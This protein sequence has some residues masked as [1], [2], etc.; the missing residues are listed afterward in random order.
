MKHLVISDIHCRPIGLSIANEEIGNVDMV[1]FL[2]DYLDS[3]DESDVQMLDNFKKIIEFK[4]TYDDKVI[5]LLGN[6]CLSY[7]DVKYKCSGFRPQL[8]PQIYQLFTENRDIFQIAYQYKNYLFTHAGVS[9]EWLNRYVLDDK[10]LM[11]LIEPD[12]NNM[13]QFLNDMGQTRFRAELFKAGASR[14]SIGWGGPLWADKKE[15]QGDY[16]KG[17]IQV[18]GHTGIEN[19][20]YF[21][22]DLQGIWYTDVLGKKR[23]YLILDI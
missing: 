20:E 18:V 4:K 9:N 1:L 10:E 13:G 6:H 17:F 11:E 21:G 15:T 2:G 5:L 3:F 12:L 22:D 8:A 16:L 7:M 19:I 14:G 23:D